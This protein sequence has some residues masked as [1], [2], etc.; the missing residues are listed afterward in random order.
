[1]EK[2]KNVSVFSVVYWH[3]EGIIKVLREKEPFILHD[4]WWSYDAMIYTANHIWQ[5]SLYWKITKWVIM[6]QTTFLAVRCRTSPLNYFKLH[7]DDS[8][9]TA[10]QGT[11]SYFWILSKTNKYMEIDGRLCYNTRSYHKS[12]RMYIWDICIGFVITLCICRLYSLSS[13]P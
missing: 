9:T 5:W 4:C 13:L 8:V 6:H 1:M 12:H 3:R 10:S 2:Y 11:I 7:P